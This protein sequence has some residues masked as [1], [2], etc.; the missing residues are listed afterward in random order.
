MGASSIDSATLARVVQLAC[1]APSVHNSQPWRMSAQDSELR[2][3]LEPHRVPHATDRSGR[4]AVIS[5]GA[6]LD[7]LRVAATA[8]GWKAH[9]ARF[10]NPSELDHL[11]TVEFRRAQFVSDAERARADAILQRRTDRLPFAAPASWDFLE[12]VLRATIDTEK[13]TLTVLPDSARSQLA[14]ASRLTE[15]MRRYDSSYQAEL[16][17]WTSA[18][19]VSDGIPY[20]A[21]ASASERGR[22]EVA[23]AFPSD[24]HPDRRPQLD[25]DHSVIAVLCTDGDGR[26]EALGCGEVL[27]DVLLEATMAGL[28]TCTLTH[29]T[30]LDAS[31]AIIRALVGDTGDPQVLIRIG[32]VP[33]FDAQPPATPRRPLADVFG[34]EP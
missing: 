24:S 17:W 9:I 29:L 12:P 20:S 15:A 33:A 23:R 2:M 26:R 32:Q 31:R 1:R 18:F 22:V 13:A 3:F 16:H 30:E 19:E 14:E 25:R 4:E 28:A 7:H 34:V 6:L 21:L 5:C 8:A 10:P 27:S 11:A